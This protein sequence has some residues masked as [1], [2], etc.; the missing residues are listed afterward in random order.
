MA[1]EKATAIAALRSQLADEHSSAMAQASAEAEAAKQAALAALREEL[2]V[3]TATQVSEIETAWK[4]TMA[5]R[6]AAIQGEKQ[7]E[8]ETLE[9]EHSKQLATLGRKLADTESEL[10]GARER[11][12]L[13]AE[14]SSELESKLTEVEGTLSTTS[15][16]LAEI[17]ETQDQL[18]VDL[19]QV[20]AARDALQQEVDQSLARVALLESDKRDLESRV[21]SLDAVKGQLESKLSDAVEKIATDEA[22][23]DRVRKAMAIGLTLLEEQRNN[24]VGGANSETEGVSEDA[25]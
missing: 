5:E 11:E 2:D 14:R 12:Q 10:S 22:L 7:L 9:A 4:R 8:V 16:Q 6:E 15:A 21:G 18:Q 23:L 24:V 13:N 17:R 20:T 1:N 19:G 3:A 25:E